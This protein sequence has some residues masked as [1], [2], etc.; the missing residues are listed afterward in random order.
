[1]SNEV[2]TSVVDDPPLVDEKGLLPAL[3]GCQ[4]VASLP[5]PPPPGMCPP[6]RGSPGTAGLVAGV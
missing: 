2:H 1:M 6:P 3:Q 4:Q 5:L